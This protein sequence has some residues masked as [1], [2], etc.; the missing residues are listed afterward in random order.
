MT[1]LVCP[2]CG[3]R[4]LNEFEFRKTAPQSSGSALARVYLRIDRPDCSIE[5]WQHALG[6]RAWLLVQR[7]PSTGAVASIRLL[8]ADATRGAR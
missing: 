1:R 5:H 4:E 8:G 7:N 3:A 2:F 6:C